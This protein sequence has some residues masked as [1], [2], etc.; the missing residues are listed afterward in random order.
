MNKAL[1]LIITIFL[2]LSVIWAST[3]GVLAQGQNGINMG[4]ISIDEAIPQKE[5]ANGSPIASVPVAEDVTYTPVELSAQTRNFFAT[6]DGNI[7]ITIISSQIDYVSGEYFDYY[8]KTSADSVQYYYDVLNTLKTMAELN[9]NIKLQFLDPFEISSRGFFEENKKYSLQYG[10]IMI[11]CY[12]NF[13]GNP[14]TRKSVITAES[15]FSYNTKGGNK[16]IKSLKLENMLVKTL[17]ELRTSRDVN[18]AYIDEISSPETFEYVKSYMAGSGYN[19]DSITLKSE[20]LNGYDM[21]IICSPIRDLTL[22]ELV[23]LDNFLS[24]GGNKSFMYLAPEGYVELSLLKS[25]LIKWGI[26]IDQSKMLC[27]YDEN[28]YFAKTTQL[29]ATPHN[30][31]FLDESEIKGSLIMDK[32]APIEIKGGGAVKISTMLSTL[33]RKVVTTNRVNDLNTKQI[34]DTNQK[35]YPLITLS[36]RE[37]GDEGI[38]RVLVYA[39]V[40]FITTYFAL[41]NDKEEN[42]SGGLN[43]NLQMFATIMNNVNSLHRDTLSGL[44]DYAVSLKEQGIDTTS[45]YEVNYIIRFGVLILAIPLAV[46]LIIILIFSRRKRNGQK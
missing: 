18:V 1:K 17:G 20:Q 9:T 46:L 41:Q 37:N 26:T 24:L 33:S 23:L 32:C 3:F 15:V 6:V 12:T 11:S 44:S 43:G 27:T 42:I 10:D 38:S 36:E 19:L 28:G 25:F 31:R 30:A 13:D 29:K 40:D 2:V 5:V 7:S 4:T 45:G 22:E 35:S 21:I 16:K 39:S 8:Y 14:K 34:E